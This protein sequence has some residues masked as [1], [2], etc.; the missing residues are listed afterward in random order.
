MLLT[1][2][3]GKRWQCRN[4]IKCNNWCNNWSQRLFHTTN[5]TFKCTTQCI[6][7]TRGVHPALSF[8]LG[9]A[10]W[11]SS[12][13]TAFTSPCRTQTEQQTWGQTSRPANATLQT[14][15]LIPVYQSPTVYQSHSTVGHWLPCLGSR[16]G[17]RLCLQGLLQDC[18]FSADQNRAVWSSK[19][20]Y[21]Y[22]QLGEDLF[23]EWN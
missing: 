14:Q 10:P 22:V 2:K 15:Q 8:R 21:L 13:L 7:L 5:D 6:S 3:G 12:S 16:G 20:K 4:A 9:S 17:L 19:D 1:G 18:L 23:F 11:S